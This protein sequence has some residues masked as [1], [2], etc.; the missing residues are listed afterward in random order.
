MTLDKGEEF[1]TSSDISK[2]YIL[3]QFGT[4]LQ[5]C[6]YIERRFAKSFRARGICRRSST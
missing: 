3:P 2:K 4:Y 5:T 1:L 6:I